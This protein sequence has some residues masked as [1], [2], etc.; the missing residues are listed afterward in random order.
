MT[1]DMAYQMAARGDALVQKKLAPKKLRAMMRSDVFSKSVRTI[2]QEFDRLAIKY[3]RVQDEILR[4]MLRK[5]NRVA[6]EFDRAAPE[7][8]KAVSKRFRTKQEEMSISAMFQ[9]LKAREQGIYRTEQ[10]ADEAYRAAILPFHLQEATEEVKEKLKEEGKQEVEVKQDEELDAVVSQSVSRAKFIKDDTKRL[11]HDG[12]KAD[13]IA[14]VAAENDAHAGARRR[15]PRRLQ[16]DSRQG[17]L[18]KLKELRDK[19][20]KEAESVKGGREAPPLIPES[21]HSISEAPALPDDPEEASKIVRA[22]QLELAEHVRECEREKVHRQEEEEEE[23]EEESGPTVAEAERD[24]ETREQYINIHGSFPFP[25]YMPPIPNPRDIRATWLRVRHPQQL[26]S[27]SLPFPIAPAED[28]DSETKAR[29]MGHTHATS[30]QKN[31]EKAQE[32]LGTK[33]FARSRVGPEGAI[34]ASVRT[35]MNS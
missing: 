26:P 28:W 31:L 17:A 12:K 8:Y 34:R 2:T 4:N 33:S 24:L 19:A 5:Q 20:E 6:K 25:K 29:I 30:I 14:E 21:G 3:P 23:V 35:V 18:E 11:F 22:K 16:A 13:R 1:D 7:L 32:M 15:I 27:H 9:T 10:E